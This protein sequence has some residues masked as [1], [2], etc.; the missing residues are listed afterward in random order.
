MALTDLTNTTWVL[1]D[2]LS[3]YPGGTY[4]IKTYNISITT[5]T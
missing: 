4:T 1:N 5:E 2:T 3:S